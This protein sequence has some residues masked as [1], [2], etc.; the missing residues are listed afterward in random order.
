MNKPQIKT[1]KWPWENTTTELSLSI[2]TGE[3]RYL[4][5]PFDGY[6]AYTRNSRGG[7]DIKA[8]GGYGHVFKGIDDLI[9]SAG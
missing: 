8:F 2:Y 5:G 1:R 9:R 3:S 6:K 7:I 4:D